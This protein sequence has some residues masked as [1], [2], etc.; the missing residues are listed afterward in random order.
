VKTLTAISPSQIEM[1]H[2][3]ASGSS[4][5]CNRKWWLNK[6]LGLPLP[7]HPSAALGE[8]VHKGQE[9]FLETGDPSAIH[10]LAKGTLP[11]LEA[12]R[13]RQAGGRV[14][15]ERA[16]KRQ[17][18]NGLLMNGR[19]D[20]L[21]ASEHPFLVLDWKT[22]GNPAYA[23]TEEELRHNVQMLT[24]AYEA[25]VLDIELNGVPKERHPV[26]VAHVVIP[27]KG[28]TAPFQRRVSLSLEEIHAGWRRIQNISDDMLAV[29]KI[30][31]PEDVTPN[32]SA[33]SA[34]G[35]CAFRER[36]AALKRIAVSVPTTPV[37]APVTQ[38]EEH[39][40]IPT[41]TY[42]Q[43]L[44]IFQTDA[45]VRQNMGANMTDAEYAAWSGGAT[46]QA[47]AATVQRGVNPPEAGDPRTPPPVQVVTKAAPA[48]ASAE[49]KADFLSSLGWSD[50]DIASLV[51]EAFEEA[52][53]LGL[54]FEDAEYDKVE[55]V[56][57]PTGYDYTNVRKRKPVKAAPVVEEAAPR[58][59]GRPVGSKNKTTLV[60]EAAAQAEASKPAPVVVAAPAP[61]PEPVMEAPVWL[62]DPNN[63]TGAPWTLV[64]PS[65]P[66]FAQECA[67]RVVV[68]DD[69]A[70]TKFLQDIADAKAQVAQAP[71]VPPA[72][73]LTAAPP[74]DVQ[75]G[76]AAKLAEHK[77]RIMDLEKQ[78]QEAQ[79]ALVGARSAPVTA[80]TASPALVLY[81]DCL[82]EKGVAFTHLD[83]ALAP[84]MKFAAEN[85]VDEKTGKTTPVSHYSLI[86]FG[87]GPGLIAAH[88]LKNV[89][90]FSRG[91]YVCDTRSPA[92]AAV[93][94]VLRP[95][96]D[97]VVRGMGR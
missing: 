48:A 95:M 53:K 88:V 17:L 11:I 20:I 36:C 84:L 92:T 38:P 34:F 56:E 57:S 89:Q 93:L 74:L 86:P 90:E 44:S 87:K 45:A 21:D 85:Y 82:P 60:A 42:T 96:A 15:M 29:S 16:L 32:L 47:P 66:L 76:W 33:C 30:P 94:E 62:Y 67:T 3:P 27:T 80:T 46:A 28:G 63:R 59:R 6:I 40:A 49:E 39:M 4:S 81:V 68:G 12:L 19:I 75:Q 83:D 10:P 1:F 71:A 73:P 65:S 14:F 24:Y 5:G 52:A 77:A 25:T 64:S 79:A 97:V 41:C 54:K 72:L 7:Q 35:G 91:T 13:A 78:L 37:P 8:K 22:T 9:T 69:A 50:D 43:A 55:N 31:S 70:K 26:E 58:R 18:R 2:V 23:K 61:E 51:D